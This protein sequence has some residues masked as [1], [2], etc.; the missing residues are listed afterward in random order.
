M[1]LELRDLCWQILLV[2]VLVVQR[3]TLAIGSGRLYLLLTIKLE[4]KI[5][6]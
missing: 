2:F 4:A 3:D 6:I 5:S 1:W